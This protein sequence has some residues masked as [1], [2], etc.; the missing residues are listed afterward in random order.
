MSFI[1]KEDLIPLLQHHGY[2]VKTEEDIP[3]EMYTLFISNVETQLKEAVR[4]ALVSAD[5]QNRKELQKEDIEAILNQL[6]I[7]PKTK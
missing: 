1:K 3:D 7:F 6:R 5:N 2:A 4:V